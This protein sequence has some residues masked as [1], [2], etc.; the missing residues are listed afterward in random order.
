MFPVD[1]EPVTRLEFPDLALG[2]GPLSLYVLA[3]WKAF[4]I[5][6]TPHGDCLVEK[7]YVYLLGLFHW[8]K[9]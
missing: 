4:G 9:W 7:R 5:Y 2:N 8:A 1:N 6:G 3:S